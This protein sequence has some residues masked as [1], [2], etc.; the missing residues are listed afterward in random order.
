M[1]AHSRC[2]WLYCTVNRRKALIRSPMH[3]PRHAPGKRSVRYHQTCQAAQGPTSWCHVPERHMQHSNFAASMI[4]RAFV[5]VSVTSLLVLHAQGQFFEQHNL[6]P[7]DVGWS[8]QGG[9]LGLGAQSLVC[10]LTC[11]PQRYHWRIPGLW[12]WIHRCPVQISKP[13][14]GQTLSAITSS[15]KA[16]TSRQHCL[17]CNTPLASLAR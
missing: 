2:P 5:N 14:D 16:S 15:C 6:F 8:W 3:G 17:A 7:A 4:P 9:E 11:N 1:A 12:R 13:L 10:P